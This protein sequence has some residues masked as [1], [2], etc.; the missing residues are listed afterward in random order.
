MLSI[1]LKDPMVWLDRAYED[2]VVGW[3]Q[4]PLNQSETSSSEGF[5]IDDMAQTQHGATTQLELTIST[6]DTDSYDLEVVVVHESPPGEDAE[7]YGVVSLEM[8]FGK[9]GWVPSAVLPLGLLFL[10][11]LV[12]ATIRKKW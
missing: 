6:G 9:K 7:T 1:F 4:V 12:L 8:D 10:S 3:V 11:T 5:M 2:V